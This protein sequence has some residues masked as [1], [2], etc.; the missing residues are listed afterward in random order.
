MMQQLKLTM[1]PP[2]DD[3]DLRIRQEPERARVAGHKEKGK[4]GRTIVSSGLC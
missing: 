3:Y 1:L 2:S 4:S